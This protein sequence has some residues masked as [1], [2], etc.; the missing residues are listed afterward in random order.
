M[1]RKSAMLIIAVFAVCGVAVLFQEVAS[2]PADDYP[3]RNVSLSWD[4][5]V[6]DIVKRLTVE[7]MQMQMALGGPDGPAPAIPRLGIG[8]YQ[9]GS[10]C[11][12]GD[13]QAPGFATAFP[14]ALG[15]AATFDYD[16]I[17]RVAEAISV[18]VRGK[19]NDFVKE[20]N[21][22]WHTSASCFSPLIN[23]MRDARWGRNQETY[24]ED[25]Y[26]AGSLATA[27]IKGLQGTHLR[28]VRASGCCKHMN[29]HGGPE[30]IPVSRFSFNA[31]VSEEDWRM[32]HLPAF[33]TCV[34]AGTLA[35]MCSYNRINGVP[36]CA[37]KKL[38]TDIARNEWGF[39]GYF[40]SDEGAVENII[41]F[42]KYFN[43]SLDTAVACANA[44]CDIEIA[45]HLN[46]LPHPVYFSLVEAVKQGRVTEATLR[47]RVR[48]L[49]Y[50]RMRLG[51]FDPP[52]MN[53]Y[54]KLTSAVVETPAHKALAVEA[55][56]K[57][58]VLLK[59]D[60]GLPVTGFGTIGVVGPF[61]NTTKIFGDYSPVIPDE[62]KSTVLQAL[63]PLASKVQFAEGCDEVND[64]CATY[65][66]QSVIKAVTN[67]DA[68]FVILGTGII[69]EAEFF[70]RPDMDLPGHQK[71]LLQDVLAHSGG[72]PTYLLLFNAGPLNITFAHQEPSVVAIL[73]CFFPAQAAAEAIRHV[74]LN[75]V[76]GAVPS[77][78]L[79]FTWP[80]LASQLPPMV[81]Y[82]MKRRTYRYFEGEPLYPFGY[83]L[84]YTTFEYSNLTHSQSITAGESLSLSFHLKNS[85]KVDADEVVQ[86]YIGW[87]DTS[88]PAP[89]IQL[90]RFTRVTIEAGQQV[91]VKLEVE[92]KIMGLW[93][94]DGWF[95]KPGMMDV[96]VGGQQPN[97][98]RMAGSNVLSSSFT[99]TDM[100]YLG[101]Y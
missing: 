24:G 10:E 52:E 82:S 85:G 29:V 31:I 91:I 56:M 30:D 67:T 71:Q 57:S 61:G 51:E 83:G 40:T 19:H 101:R 7:E 1:E 25:P 27:Y 33:K 49:F 80:L 87:R 79:P 50:T 78:R 100:K 47:E 53:P 68:N 20:K 75:D 65:D 97:Q 72:K 64:K 12:R 23:I 46:V 6:E 48:P 36:A 35:L 86:V 63:T 60:G 76:P 66:S 77:G 2:A 15:L 4:V 41:L 5:R 89:K 45:A 17:Y 62:N 37:N 58:F 81:D 54:S 92:A 95:I 73:E 74:L 70:D 22:V 90:A 34:D 59:N 32:T 99:I 3:Y 13:A 44:G 8:A 93:I 28:Y 16:L 42:H 43:N 98:K 94:N 96:F 11:L 69:Y 55:A 84:S 39:R 26:V 88:L 18:E 21:F 9:W 14:Q 38:L